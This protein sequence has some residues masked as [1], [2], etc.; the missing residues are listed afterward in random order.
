MKRNIIIRPDGQVLKIF[1]PGDE[2]LGLEQRRASHVEPVNRALRGI[3]HFIRR[4]CEDD[5][6]LA[7]FTRKWPCR[8]QARIFD[9]PTLG[10]FSK[11]EEA[12]TAE[13]SWIEN[14]LEEQTYATSN[15]HCNS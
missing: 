11:R 10:P 13:I 4:R 1:D 15:T 9:G 2:E 3:F 14:A 7:A 8:W 6:K 5:S 12:I